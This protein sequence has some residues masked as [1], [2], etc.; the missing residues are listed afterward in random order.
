M[1]RLLFEKRGGSDAAAV[2]QIALEQART[3]V[4]LPLHPQA[5]VYLNARAATPP[6][7]AAAALPRK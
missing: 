6:K 4:N 3:G 5:E 7:P 2:S 1:M